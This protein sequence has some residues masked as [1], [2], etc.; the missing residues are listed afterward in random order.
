MFKIDHFAFGKKAFGKTFNYLFQR[1]KC[2]LFQQNF[3]NNIKNYRKS[4]TVAANDSN[5]PLN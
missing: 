5:G 4:E 2:L 3:R 1:L